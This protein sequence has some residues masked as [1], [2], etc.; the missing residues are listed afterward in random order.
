MN[1]YFVFI[2]A[3]RANFPIDWMCH[4]LSVS[5]ASYYRW[6]RP[7][8]PT[9][10][11]TRHVEL[12]ARVKRA[13]DAAKGKAG[14]D[15][16]THILAAEGIKIAAGTVGAIMRELGLRAVRMRAWKKTTTADPDARTEHIVNHMLDA[17]GRRD[18]SSP[19]PGT[20]LCGD[21]TYLRTGSG[22][23]YLATV[24][25]LHTR[26]VI[27]WSMASHMR[28]SLVIDALVMARDH[29]HLAAAKVVFHS[30]RGSQYTSSE[31]Q[32]WCRTNNVTQSM[33]AVGTCWDNAVAEC[34]FS[35]LKTEMYHQQHFVNHLQARTAVMEYI[36]SWYNRRR[37]H[38]FNQGLTPA[39]ALAAHQAACRPAA[40]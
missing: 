23:L 8:D 29:G 39:A 7:T 16:I 12:A 14:R 13:F 17:D 24:I 19:A 2:T 11:G 15:Q 10:T 20:K 30:D 33:G 25:D 32:S 34:F 27:G 18:F 38:G 9:P 35:H 22:W 21:I 31:F 4:K 6:T 1:D 5:R 36:E 26:M 3:Q 37:P 40:A 28:T